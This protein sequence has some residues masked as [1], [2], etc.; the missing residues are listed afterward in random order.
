[1]FCSI[2]DRDKSASLPIIQELLKKQFKLVATEGTALFFQHN[3]IS[4]EQV[5]HDDAE[6]NELFRKQSIMAVINIPN[7]GRKKHKFGF[8]I[9][10]HAIRYKIPIFTHLDTIEATIN[11]QKETLADFD[12]RTI[13]EYYNFEKEVLF[14]LEAY[15]L[16]EISNNESIQFNGK[17]FYSFQISV[18]TKSSIFLTRHKN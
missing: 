12:V 14:M 2:S 6:V 3:D 4:V 7:Q 9:R 18:Q 16:K 11:L 15:K 1:M 8:K 5:V 13:S 17:D 10:E